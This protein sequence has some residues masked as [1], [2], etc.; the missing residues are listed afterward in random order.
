MDARSRAKFHMLKESEIKEKLHSV[1]EPATLPPHLLGSSAD[2][3]S[4]VDIPFD[5]TSVVFP[6]KEHRKTHW[7]KRGHAA[8]ES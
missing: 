2:Y 5:H 6:S 3:Q 8:A 4:S 1:F 7:G